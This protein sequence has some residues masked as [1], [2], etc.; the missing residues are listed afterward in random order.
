MNGVEVNF[1][2]LVGPTH[3]YSGLALGNLASQ[4]NSH[5]VS[6][7]REAAK[8][9]LEKMKAL[10][11]LG[12]LQGV[13]P[14]HDRPDIAT[15]RRLGFTGSE[16]EILSK[17]AKQAPALLAAVSSASPMW[18]A[19]AATVSPSADSEDHRLH[20]TP[21]NLN[22][23]FHRS[24]EATTT[25]RLLTTLF[26]DETY[27]SVHEPLPAQRNWGDEGAANHTRLCVDH[28]GPG[29][30]LF[31][32]GLSVLDASLPRPQRFGARQTLEA[33]H[34]IARLHR[35]RPAQLVFAQ[36][37]PDSIDKGVFHNDVIA[38]GHRHLL[39]LHERAFV[40]Q[41]QVLAEIA[42]KMTRLGLPFMALEVPEQEVSVEEA[43]SSYLFNS[44]LLS[45]ADGSMV[46]IVP[47]ECQRYP[48][49]RSYLE[50]LVTADSNPIAA[51]HV[52]NLR[53]SMQN[54]GG[55]ACLRL[56]VA[57][58]QDEFAALKPEVMLTE[59]LFVTLVAW[60]E[61]HYRDHLL[62]SDLADPQLLLE[63]R[64]AL[65]ELTGILGLGSVYPFQ[66]P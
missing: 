29:V 51:L 14:P 16:A 55:P 44:Q 5:S 23:S 53:Q 3:N 34:A 11:D 4:K 17:V 57:L 18:V 63:S 60:V 20:I 49:V 31:V 13:I 37:R 35:L 33:S 28:A 15:L 52:F 30:E 65:D 21:A 39:L 42:E 36:Q 66:R 19:N 12:F 43:V 2:G 54:G 10:H 9:G 1:D 61:R 7:P 27:F 40:E 64:C 25:H 56:R 48:S 41:T 59:A 32:F 22:A 45:R 50:T 46:L 8:Q 58:T 24:I 38:V 26:A 6:N 47:E 62:P